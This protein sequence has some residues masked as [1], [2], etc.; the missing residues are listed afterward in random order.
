MVHSYFHIMGL[1]HILYRHSCCKVCKVL[2]FPENNYP[3]LIPHC[4]GEDLRVKNIHKLKLSE[5]SE[6]L[7][8][9]RQ[10]YFHLELWTVYSIRDTGP[11]EW[12][13]EDP[14]IWKDHVQYYSLTYYIQTWKKYHKGLTLYSLLPHNI[15]CLHD[16]QLWSFIH[17]RGGIK[18]KLL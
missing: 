1:K 8:F 3:I 10:R 9:L 5:Y 2:P 18:G 4:L 13:L 16:L 7:I 15:I 12:K 14:H 6:P 17:Y 11:Q